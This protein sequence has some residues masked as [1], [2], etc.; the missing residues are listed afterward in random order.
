MDKRRKGKKEG[1]GGKREEAGR[2][3]GMRKE[4]RSLRKGW[5]RWRQIGGIWKQEGSRKEDKGDV[6]GSGK[7]E[8]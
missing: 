5:E 2:E 8:G 7:E 1:E 6:G 3:Y 4:G